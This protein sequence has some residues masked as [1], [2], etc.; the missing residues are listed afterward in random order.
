M[1]CGVLV[2]AGVEGET[3]EAMNL[4]LFLVHECFIC[5]LQPGAWRLFVSRKGRQEFIHIGYRISEIY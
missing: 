2:G 1:G 4:S 3:E 5:Y